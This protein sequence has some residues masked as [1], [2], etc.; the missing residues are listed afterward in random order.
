MK[1]P[2]RRQAES[3]QGEQLA[4]LPEPPFCPTWPKPG[5]LQSR[6]LDLLVAGRM[7]DHADFFATT[8]SWRLAEYIAILRDGGWPIETVP[9]PAPT[10]DS[11][12]RV[13]ALYCLPQEHKA[14][15]LALIGRAA[16]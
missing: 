16:A 1:S 9:V 3:G 5:T 13:I 7:F 2:D 6:A 10:E 4:L 15:A 14:Q 12:H 11:P 8:G